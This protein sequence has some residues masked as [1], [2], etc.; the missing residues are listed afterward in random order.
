MDLETNRDEIH[1]EWDSF[2]KAAE[3]CPLLE[4]LTKEIWV[5]MLNYSCTRCFGWTLPCTMMVPLADF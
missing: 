1:I 2:S 5:E 4:G 3:T